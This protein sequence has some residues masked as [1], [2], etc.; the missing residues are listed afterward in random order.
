MTGSCAIK[1]AEPGRADHRRGADRAARTRASCCAPP[2]RCRRDGGDCAF[3][4]LDEAQLAADPERG[5]VFTDRLLHARGREETMIL[6]SATL[7]PM[8]RALVPEAEIDRPPAL[9]DAQ[10]CRRAQALAPAAALGDRRL[11]GRGGLC[12][13]RDAAPVA[14]R[15]GGGDGRALARERATRRSRCSRR[16]RSIISSP[17]TR[18]AWGSTSTSRHVAFAGAAQIRRASPAP[19]DR[20]RNGADRRP[21]RAP[22]ARRHL[23]HAR[24]QRGA[25]AGSRTRRSTRSRSIASRRSTQLFWREAEPRLRQHRR[26]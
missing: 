20:R 10:L 3:V 19:A 21:R 2:N 25:G 7:E 5:H 17:P 18:S 6:G 4:A 16:A 22:P 13:R 1:G 15:R 24:G 26:R 12:R 11:L 9:L 8:V 23:R 14:R